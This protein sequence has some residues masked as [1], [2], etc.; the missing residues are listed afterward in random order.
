M[1]DNEII[2]LE[3]GAIALS[4]ISNADKHCSRRRAEQGFILSCMRG[5][6]D[7]D[8]PR[9][10]TIIERTFENHKAVIL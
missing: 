4:K 9:Y 1:D 7:E 3:G 2:N 8:V 5:T 6:Y 10:M